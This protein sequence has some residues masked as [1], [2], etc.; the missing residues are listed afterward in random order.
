MRRIV[1]LGKTG[2]GK[3]SVANT[4]FGEPQFTVCHNSISGTSLCEAKTQS[5]NGGQITLIDTPG[6]FDTNTPEERLR[7]EIVQCITECSPGPHAFLIVLKLETF[8]KL[9]KKIIK[10][11]N[12]YFSEEVFNFATV[13]FTHGDDLQEGLK[14][15]DFVSL[16][17]HL[18]ALVKKCGGRCHV[19]DNRYWNNLPG[20]PYRS[21]THQVEEILKSVEEIV[22]ANNGNCYTNE[23]LEKVEKM[24]QQEEELIAQSSG[25]MSKEE[26]RQEAKSRACDILNKA[27]GITTGVLLGALFGAAVAIGVDVVAAKTASIKAEA[28]RG[29]IATVLAPAPAATSGAAAGIAGI[30]VGPAALGVGAAAGAV[31]GAYKGYKAAEESETPWEAA[32]K[33]AESVRSTAKDVCSSVEAV[34]SSVEDAKRQVKKFSAE[35]QN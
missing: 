3:S 33:T 27:V 2:S 31:V 23:M 17:K 26:I 30:K 6:F 29:V 19:I 24:I 18:R 7:P 16:N 5:L 22:K 25:N 12:K 9:E 10:Q 34:R 28:I 35:Y 21:N 13:V 4:I 11:I 14:I 15:K 20:D 32:K 8:T 1:I